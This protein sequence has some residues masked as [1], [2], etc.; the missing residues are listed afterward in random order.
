MLPEAIPA[1]GLPP[2]ASSTWPS[3]SKLVRVLQECG[4]PVEW[5][6]EVTA[7]PSFLRYFVIPGRQTRMKQVRGIAEDLGIRLN[8]TSDPMIHNAG[9]RLAIDIARPDPQTVTFSSILEQLPKPDGCGC[10]RTP[11][12]VD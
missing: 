8:L 1:P 12:G 10:S 2:S 9:G 11:L 3:E 4:A 7:G 5:K 6:G